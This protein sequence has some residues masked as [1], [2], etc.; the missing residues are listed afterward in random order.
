MYSD[1]ALE[2][3]TGYDVAISGLNVLRTCV[4]GTPSRGGVTT[5]IGR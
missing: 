4:Q 3:A 2:I 5:G 1:D